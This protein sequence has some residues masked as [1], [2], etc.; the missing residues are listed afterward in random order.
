VNSDSI[1]DK[2]GLPGSVVAKDAYRFSL[3]YFNGDYEGIGAEARIAFPAHSSHMTGHLNGYRPLYN[4]NIS[5]MVV[6]IPK[7]GETKLYNYGYDQLNRI[8]SMDAWGGYNTASLSWAD[9]T[10]SD[11]YKERI[12]YDGNGNI[13]KYLRNGAGTALDMDS[14]RYGY[15]QDIN[16]HLENNRLRHVRDG[17][18][19]G[20]YAV[21]I[22][23]QGDD[24][25]EYDAIGNLVKD[26]KEGI[27]S[28]EWTVYGKIKRITKANG[29]IIS[30]SYDVTGNRISKT[31]TEGENTTTTWY[32]RDAQGN[33]MAVFKE[34][35]ST[36]ALNEHHLYGS[37]RLGLWDRNIDMSGD[38]LTNNQLER[39]NKYFELSNH[40]GNVLVTVSDKKAAVDAD[41]DG[42]VDFYL[43]DVVSAT[44]YYPF[45]MQMVGRKFDAGK[46]RYGFNGKEKDNDVKGE[47]NQYDYGFRVYDSR[48]G[49]FLSVDPLFKGYPWNCPY[50]YA[51]GDVIRAI[52]LDGLEKYVV[53]YTYDRFGR[54]VNAVIS[55]ISVK[56]TNLAVEMNLRLA[57]NSLLTTNEV[58][59]IHSN[60]FNTPIS[61]N[62]R[63]GSQNRGLTNAE[64]SALARAQINLPGDDDYDTKFGIVDGG[65]RLG[66]NYQLPRGRAS[67]LLDGT[68]FSTHQHFD[69]NLNIGRTRTVRATANLA[70]ADFVGGQLGRNTISGSGSMD[71][72]IATDYQS[73]QI[74]NFVNGFLT[75]NNLNLAFVDR[76]TI[77]IGSNDSRQQWNVV[78]KNLQRKYRAL[79]DIVVDRNS[80]E[81]AGGNSSSTYG[82]I[83]I[84]V[85][86]VQG[87]NR[88]FA[89]RGAIT[90]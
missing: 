45:G 2:D 5:S 30:Y 55:G 15:N 10:T 22:D 84:N 42:D 40:L 65:E 79:V 48:L 73:G 49:K 87:G 78:Q 88:T 6:G 67:T 71:S 53:N 86:G 25:Y 31:I 1:I 4:G 76:I 11:E 69:A 60:R 24:N 23:S 32:T 39:G 29:T 82:E 68:D 44:D 90:R 9:M 18:G 77:T 47:G 89:D 58:Y 28:I 66:R 37:S 38:P 83:S 8:V 34:Q 7:L 50:S 36:L 35:S 41:T 63:G 19:D 54:R 27:T 12:A 85:S 17:I 80:Q 13:L 75:Q 16:G 14:L 74:D 21:D 70:G 20:N 72:Q 46:Y 56:S 62:P 51:E 26:T 33:T 3:N 64:L 81:G 61:A 43:S 52:D 59:E 57:N